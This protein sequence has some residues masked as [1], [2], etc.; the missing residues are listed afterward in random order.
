M[1]LVR[2]RDWMGCGL[3]LRFCVLFGTV[4]VFIVRFGWFL[5]V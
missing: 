1:I 2:E 3:M 4:V 5:A